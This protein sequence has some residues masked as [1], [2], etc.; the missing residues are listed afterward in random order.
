MSLGG[1]V[2]EVQGARKGGRSQEGRAEPGREGGASRIV[3][4]EVTHRKVL[5]VETAPPTGHVDHL[6][7]QGLMEPPGEGNA[8]D[9]EY[10]YVCVCVCVYALDFCFVCLLFV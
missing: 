2:G 6:S 8:R 7:D 3:R 10:G 1:H 4:V 5:A 9:C